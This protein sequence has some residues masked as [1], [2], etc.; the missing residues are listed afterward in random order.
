MNNDQTE[1]IPC[2]IVE[3]EKRAKWYR[4]VA[5]V[6]VVLIIVT[7]FIGAIVFQLIAEIA[8]SDIQSELII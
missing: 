2:L 1:P 7:F 8:Q 5:Y 3:L 6:M 4:S